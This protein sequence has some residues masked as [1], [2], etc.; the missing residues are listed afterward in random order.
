MGPSC[1]IHLLLMVTWFDLCSLSFIE[2][3]LV[4]VALLKELTDFNDF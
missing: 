3:S 1:F 2:F 4:F